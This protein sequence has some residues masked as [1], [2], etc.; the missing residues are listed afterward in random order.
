MGFALCG[1][2]NISMY[3]TWQTQNE[4]KA[5]IGYE[6][7]EAYDTDCD[8]SEDDGDVLAFPIGMEEGVLPSAFA[9][10]GYG[11]TTAITGDSDDV[12]S[13]K[14]ITASLPPT[15]LEKAFVNAP[16][17]GG[18][19]GDTSLLHSLF[20]S[21]ENSGVRSPPSSSSSALRPQRPDGPVELF[22]NMVRANVDR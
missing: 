13:G 12:I 2:V 4:K 15:L 18:E 6:R 22:S 1:G 8:S 17:D 20:G 9:V 5:P 11:L 10:T 7:M 3:A 16:A 21:L 19:R 14:N